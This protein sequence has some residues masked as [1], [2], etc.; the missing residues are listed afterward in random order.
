MMPTSSAPSPARVYQEYFVPA[1]FEPWARVLVE[2]ADLQPGE[3][4]LDVAC[5][6]GI[7]ARTAASRVAP[8]GRVAALDMNPAMLEVARDLP[9]DAPPPIEWQQ[10]SATQLPYGDA[11][12]DVVLCQ[13]GFQF[14][15]DR[16]QAAR[17]M[18]RVLADGGRVAVIVLQAIER[19]PVF[20][21][22]MGALAH[23]LGRPPSQFAVPFALAD[24]KELMQ[25]FHAAGF[26]DVEVEPANIEARFP[27]A[28]RFVPLM[29]ASSAAAVPAFAELQ[30]PERESLLRSVAVD[31]KPVL[32]R[33]RQG[34][35]IA[36]PMWA[37]VLRACR[38]DA[39]GR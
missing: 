9:A 26:G 5:G 28:E 27:D 13:H 21:S 19:H 37:H 7:V 17:E 20:E 12:F 16:V 8:S 25:H 3:R 31:A 4:V 2:R 39:R 33:F 11:Q 15:P 14:F 23:R 18:H 30:T 1:M 29:A 6:T 38:Q 34:D 35:T 36:F 24:A 32:E 22:I 10:G